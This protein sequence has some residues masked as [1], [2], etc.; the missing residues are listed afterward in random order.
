MNLVYKGFEGSYWEP[1][2]P[3]VFEDDFGNEGCH[4]D[5]IV[6]FSDGYRCFINDSQDA[7]AFMREFAEH[8]DVERNR[9]KN[10]SLF[11][12]ADRKIRK[13]EVYWVFLN[14]PYSYKTLKTIDC[15]EFAA[16]LLGLYVGEFDAV[17][18]MK[19]VEAQYADLMCD[20]LREEG[21]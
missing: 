3:A 14:E 10:N 13:R 19:D 8:I 12:C 20:L 1:P 6:E 2:E 21:Y 7:I 18:Y 4:G 9:A 16:E 17:D 15:I 5:I 11:D